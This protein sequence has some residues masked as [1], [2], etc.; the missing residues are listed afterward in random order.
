VYPSKSAVL[1]SLKLLSVNFVMRKF[2][3]TEVELLLLPLLFLGVVVL[4]VQDVIII[5]AT[6]IKLIIFFI[7]LLCSKNAAIKKLYEMKLCEQEKNTAESDN[8]LITI[9]SCFKCSYFFVLIRRGSSAIS[10]L[11]SGKFKYLSCRNIG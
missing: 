11:F 2:P 7:L 8:N 9:R 4:C 6:K 10:I 3:L 5:A 1:S